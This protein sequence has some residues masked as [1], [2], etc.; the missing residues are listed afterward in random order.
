M[1]TGKG[2]A[3][4][5]Q[6]ARSLSRFFVEL[7]GTLGTSKEKLDMY[8][9]LGAAQTRTEQLAATTKNLGQGTAKPFMGTDKVTLGTDKKTLGTDKVTRGVDKKTLGTDKVARGVDKV[10]LGTGLRGQ[11]QDQYTLGTYKKNLAPYF[12]R[13]TE[14]WLAAWTLAQSRPGR[15]YISKVKIDGHTIPQSQVR[16]VRDMEKAAQAAALLCHFR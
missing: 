1:K 9:W 8:K 16:K 6:F 2:E 5:L 10:T 12:R 14:Q 3:E 7:D 4:G 13:S 11:G 15:A